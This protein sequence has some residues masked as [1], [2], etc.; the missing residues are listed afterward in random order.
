MLKKMKCRLDKI[1]VHYETR[2]KGRPL[3]MLHGVYL[4]RRMMIGCMEPILRNRRGWQRIYLDLPGMG[5]SPGEEWIS[6]SDQM[7]EVVLDF[8]E[9]VIPHQRFALAGESYGGY[10]A[11]GVVY[12]KLQQIDGLLLI[13]PIIIA[14]LTKRLLPRHV[15]LVKEVSVRS[16][17]YPEEA[18]WFETYAVVQTP[19]TWKREIKEVFSGMKI[20]DTK[21]LDRLAA[22]YS[23]SFDVDSFPGTFDKPTLIVAGR[24]D[25]LVGY[26]DAW[27]ILE[28]YPRATFAV[29]DR[30]GHI[31]YIEQEHLFNALVKEWLGRVEESLNP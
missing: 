5:E 1:T 11:R 2:G 3:I 13:L 27:T 21:F 9:Q 4:D 23:F 26:R 28:K 20:A 8:I 30:A 19:R 15:T 25:S 12:H 31:L 17:L 22:Q 18:K 6:G 10:L 14:D 16:D 7:L 29:L 24:Q